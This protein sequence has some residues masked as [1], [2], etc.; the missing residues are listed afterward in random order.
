MLKS[1]DFL[2]RIIAPV[3]GKWD[4]TLSY[5]CPHC[6]NFLLDGYIC[7]A[8][9]G[10]KHFSWWSVDKKYE[11]GA[12]NRILVE[13]TDVSA[14]QAKVFKAQTA[15][16]GL[17]ENLIHALKLLAIH[18]K[19]GDNPIQIVIWLKVYGLLRYDGRSSKRCVPRRQLGK[20]PRNWRWEQKKLAPRKRASMSVTLRR[21]VPAF[22]RLV[23]QGT[24]GSEWRKLYDYN[25]EKS[26]A[27]GVKKSNESQRVKALWKMKAT[28]DGGEGF[29]DPERKD[30]ILGRNRTRLELREEHLKDPIVALDNL[31][32]AWRSSIK[33]DCWLEPLCG[34]DFQWPSA[35]RAQAW[36]QRCGTSLWV[37]VFG[38]IWIR[39]K[40]CGCA[41]PRRSEM[42][43]RSMD[44]T[45][46]F[47]CSFW[48][49]S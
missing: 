4:V 26:E 7:L 41:Q 25:K 10:K 14:S 43:P 23:L 12:S 32:S 34:S 9:T 31:W 36:C 3:G 1:T 45:M 38:L 30:N 29:Y 49:K 17:C 37:K 21:T 39:G 48:R 22:G 15:P 42:S 6:N 19:D 16:Q 24:G 20:V 5:L 28:R 44:R 35:E 8:S 18:Q 27:A 40:V 2:R 46:S 11:C 33:A 47:S 13:Q